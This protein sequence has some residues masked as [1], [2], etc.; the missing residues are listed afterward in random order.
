MRIGRVAHVAAS[1]RA[2][3]ASHAAMASLKLHPAIGE[4]RAVAAIDVSDARLD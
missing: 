3:L 1:G 4:T 2:Y